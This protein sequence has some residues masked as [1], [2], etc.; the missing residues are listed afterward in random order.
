M[1]TPAGCATRCCARVFADA[2]HRGDIITPGS[3][4][5]FELELLQVK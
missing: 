4:L 2:W 1:E 5:V 3:V